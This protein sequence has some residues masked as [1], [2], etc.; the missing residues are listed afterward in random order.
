[1]IFIYLAA[2]ILH[3]IVP[4]FY[5]NVMPEWLPAGSF[6]VY[7]SGT[8]E[9]IFALMLVSPQWRRMGAWSIIALLLAFFVIHI[10]MLVKYRDQRTLW[11]LITRFFLQFFLI[12]WA[13]LY[14]KKERVNYE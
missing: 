14:T 10:N 11:I 2:G 4:E 3:F 9:I 1:M 12:W 13:Y 7:L 6:L 8:C 5:L